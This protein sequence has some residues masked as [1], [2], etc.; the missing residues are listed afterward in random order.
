MLEGGV[1]VANNTAR[2]ELGPRMGTMAVTGRAPTP[3]TPLL[4]AP[5][6]SSLPTEFGQVPFA[7]SV[8]PLAG[9]ARYRLQIAASAEFSTLLE[10][11]VFESP[12]LRG[13]ALA[14]GTYYLRLRG[15][16]ARQLEGMDAERGITINARPEPPFLSEPPPKHNSPTAR[17]YSAG[18]ARPRPARHTASS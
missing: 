13:P 11:A 10:D 9:A 5:D 15:I 2:V 12:L 7:F 6:L 3:P 8:P 14:D 18:R 4:A 16:D 1:R 17:L